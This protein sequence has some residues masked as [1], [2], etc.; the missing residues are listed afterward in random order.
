[1]IGLCRWPEIPMFTGARNVSVLI[2]AQRNGGKPDGEI[3]VGWS[4][5][6]LLYPDRDS[7]TRG[8]LH[9]HGQCRNKTDRRGDSSAWVDVTERV[10]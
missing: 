5:S 4:G 10:H 8:I 6:A 9:L 1:M 2:R 7:S 3:G